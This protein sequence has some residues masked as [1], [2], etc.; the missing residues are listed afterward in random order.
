[1]SNTFDWNAVIFSTL[2]AVYILAGVFVG[3][4]M[5]EKFFD[6]C[7]IKKDIPEGVTELDAKGTKE[8]NE[9]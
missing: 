4:W 8:K 1:M 7:R 9:S 6:P 2:A 3:R 5:D